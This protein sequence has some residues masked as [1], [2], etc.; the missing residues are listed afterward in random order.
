[1][2]DKDNKRVTGLYGEM[3]L[4]MELH[5]R[6]WQVYRAYI[7]ENIDFVIA[8]YYCTT[9]KKT[10][11]LYERKTNNYKCLTDTCKH[12]Q[13]KSVDIAVR[14]IQVK[15]SEGIPKDET[16]RTYSFHAK[17]RSNIGKNSYYCWI[18]IT[19]NDK[20]HKKPHYFIFHHTEINKFDDLNLDCYQITDNQKTNLHIDRNGNVL[21]KGR[22]YSYDCFEEFY[23]NFDKL[24]PEDEDE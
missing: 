8:K 9:C 15:T 21:N 18:P 22:K 6:G 16:T 4:A 3:L 17:L 5:E 12:C 14:F 7:D 2:S 13:N 23:N 11:E 20:G 19:R 24:E 10:T 1:M